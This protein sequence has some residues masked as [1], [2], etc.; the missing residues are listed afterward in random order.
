MRGGWWYP[1]KRWLGCRSF[2][3][4]FGLFAHLAVILGLATGILG[5]ARYKKLKG[6][7]KPSKLLTVMKWLSVTNIV[8]GGL[9]LG[10]WLLSIALLH[11]FL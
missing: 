11:T 7:A 6:D 5:A 10:M 3:D 4:W 8:A 9:Y 1:G 2:L